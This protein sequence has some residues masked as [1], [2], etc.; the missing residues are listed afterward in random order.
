MEVSGVRFLN[1]ELVVKFG[2]QLTKTEKTKTTTKTEQISACYV[3]FWQKWRHFF[4][5]NN[6]AVTLCPCKQYKCESFLWIIFSSLSVLNA[7]RCTTHPQTVQQSGN[8]WPNVPT[9]QRRLTT[10]AHTLK[11]YDGFACT[12]THTVSYISFIHTCNKQCHTIW[13]HCK[14]YLH[15]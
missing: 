12:H 11:M 5:V 2:L 1:K 7:V 4:K 15:Y 6:E 9:I 8:G 10:S 13:K 3:I 14:N